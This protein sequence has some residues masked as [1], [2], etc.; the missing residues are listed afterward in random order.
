MIVDAHAHIFPEHVADRAMEALSAQAGVRPVARPTVEGL[1]RHMDECGVD[2]AV[3][4]AIA[5]RPDQVR[6]ITK[7][8]ASLRTEERFI[9]FAALHPHSDDLPGDIERVV[10]AGLRGVK[11]QP[12][13]QGF[14]LDDPGVLRMLELIDDR[15]VVLM[16]GGQ[17]IAPVEQVRATPTGLRVLHRRF[18][19]V[20][21]VFAH[22]GAYRQWDEVE[23]SLVGEEVHFDAS[24]VFDLCSDEQISRI[25]RNH[26]PERILWGS[27]FPWQTQ[28]EGLEGVARLGL[29]E[30][31]RAAML[32]GNLMRLLK[33]PTAPPPTPR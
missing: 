17:D 32:G 24:Y 14:E 22:L 27:D 4:L 5:T 11:L 29:S 33:S 30:E 12:N 6:S 15:L 28:R 16:H 26:G 18:P 21:F 23:E 1:L 10:D 19:Q 13:F 7:W 2:R 25:V 3:V 20:R 31:E 9:P 8:F